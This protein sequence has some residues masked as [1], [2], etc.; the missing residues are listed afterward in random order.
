VADRPST[1]N[2][3]K[4][5]N[6]NPLVAPEHLRPATRAWFD[7]VM[8][9]F[10]LE[11]HHVRLLTLAAE[12]FDRSCEAREELAVVGLTFLGP[13]GCPHPHPCVA[14]ERDAR[15][16]FAKLLRE[17]DL[18]AVPPPQPSRPPSLRSIRR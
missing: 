3:L 2:V 4:I 12:A 1:T 14:I 7:S 17:L 5:H 9:D 6:K 13:N 15:L 10:K 11:E 16:G 18:D 8:S